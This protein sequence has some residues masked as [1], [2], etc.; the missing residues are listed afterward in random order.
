MTLT[1][2]WLFREVYRLCGF[3]VDGA[4]YASPAGI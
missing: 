1:P 4:G 3:D 2:R